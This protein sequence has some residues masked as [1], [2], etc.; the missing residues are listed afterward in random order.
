MLGTAGI[1][2][3]KE[4]GSRAVTVLTTLKCGVPTCCWPGLGLHTQTPWPPCVCTM[5]VPAR[6]TRFGAL[7]LMGVSAWFCVSSLLDSGYE[8]YARPNIIAHHKN[9]LDQQGGTIDIG[10]LS[11]T[12]GGA[13]NADT[14]SLGAVPVASSPVAVVGQVAPSDVATLTITIKSSYSSKLK[15]ASNADAGMCCMGTGTIDAWLHGGIH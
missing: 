3:L 1:A 2:S 8:P 15:V 5:A 7:G 9:D 14:G 12:H 6:A 10:G 13:D 4:P 11:Q